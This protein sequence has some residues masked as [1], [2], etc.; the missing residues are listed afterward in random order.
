MKL[1][2]DGASAI[3]KEFVSLLNKGVAK[4]Y[5]RCEK[6]DIYGCKNGK[7]FSHN[8]STGKVLEKKQTFNKGTGYLRVKVGDK[9]VEVHA[10][11]GKL[12]I[13][14]PQPDVFDCIDHIDGNKLNNNLTNLRYT[15][16]ATNIKYYHQLQ[17]E[18]GITHSQRFLTMDEALQIRAEHAKDELT[19]SELA[20]KFNQKYNVVYQVVNNLTY[21][22]L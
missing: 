2:Y 14:N 1:K 16:R 21:V 19:I 13:Y 8:R 9:P 10:I 4:L 18:K 17:R 22:N 7:V 15:D 11:L 3:E 5:Q 6:V 20:K 12:F